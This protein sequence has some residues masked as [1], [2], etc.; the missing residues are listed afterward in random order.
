MAGGGRGVECRE[1][2]KVGNG[3]SVSDSYSPEGLELVGLRD[4]FADDSPLRVPSLRVTSLRRKTGA[5]TR[6]TSERAACG[7]SAPRCSHL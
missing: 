3:D 6:G 1:R 4:N 7:H 5:R 2:E